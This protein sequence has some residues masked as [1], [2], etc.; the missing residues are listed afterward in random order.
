MPKSFPIFSE[1]IHKFIAINT[2]TPIL[3]TAGLIMYMCFFLEAKDRPNI[4]FF[5]TD[6]ISA[7]D[8]GPYGSP[9]A[10]TFRR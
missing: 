10:K 9:V 5:I 8:L 2:V 1:S 7:D 4:V 3:L 6:D